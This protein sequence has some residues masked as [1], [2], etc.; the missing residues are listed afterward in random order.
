MASVIL[1]QIDKALETHTGV[2]LAFSG[3]CQN[4]SN[5]ILDNRFS[6]KDTSAIDLRCVQ[7]LGTKGSHRTGFILP[8]NLN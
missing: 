3:L 2:F 6:R 5:E 1:A 4:V 8:V 7:L